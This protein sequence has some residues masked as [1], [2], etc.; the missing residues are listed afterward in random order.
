MRQSIIEADE[1]GRVEMRV[2]VDSGD[3]DELNAEERKRLGL[4][5]T[6]GGTA[7][8]VA[9]IDEDE[10]LALCAA[11]DRDALDFLASGYSDRRA[12]RRLLSRFPEWRCSEGAV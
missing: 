5:F 11:M 10:I 6:A 4:G 1:R 2:L 9:N 7:R 3:I 12:L 8:K